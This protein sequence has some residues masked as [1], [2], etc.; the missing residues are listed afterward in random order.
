[1]NKKYSLVVASCDAYSDLWPPFFQLLKKHWPSFDAPIYICTESKKIEVEGLDIRCPLN[2]DRKVT[3]S[4]RMLTLLKIIDSEN[5]LF[6]LDDFWIKNTV[7]EELIEKCI[8][9]LENDKN[10]GYFCL[11]SQVQ[12]PHMD[13]NFPSNKYPE[14]LVYGQKTIFRINTQIGLWRK[15]YLIKVLRKHEDVWFFET[16]ASWR[17]SHLYGNDIYILRPDIQ[18][19]IDYHLCG[20]L[21]QG[22]YIQE[23]LD[24]FSSDN[25]QLDLT[26]GVVPTMTHADPKNS[27]NRLSISY[28]WGVF[29]SMLPK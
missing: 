27:L 19:P 14:F 5:I 22:K 15:N 3:W 7:N 25:L 1:M 10:I 21:H 13:F 2:F 23:F 24:D 18:R 8:D 29:K 4:H 11:K 9:Y 28:L 17:S 26:R 20:V 16:R 6:M 12:Q